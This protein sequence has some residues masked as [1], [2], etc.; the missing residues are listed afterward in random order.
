MN[1]GS[2]P[3]TQHIN[4]DS[5]QFII[6]IQYFQKLNENSAKE[7]K[8]VIIKCNPNQLEYHKLKNDKQNYSK[9]TTDIYIIININICIYN[10]I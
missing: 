6:H 9:P 1:H 3:R 10:Y 4:P 8:Q 2:P 5:Y 7:I